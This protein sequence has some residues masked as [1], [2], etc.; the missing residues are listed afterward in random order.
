[1]RVAIITESFSPDVNGVANSVSRVADHLLARGHEPLVI[2]PRPGRRTRQLITPK[3]YPVVRLD[4][5]P[6][7]GY[8]NVRLAWPTRRIGAALRA[9]QPDVVHLASPFILGAWGAR[10]AAGLGLPVVAI[11]QT[12]VPGYARAYGVGLGEAAAWRWIRRIHA[13]AAATLAPSSMTAA[14]L[15]AN[16]VPRVGRWGRGVD[17]EL[18]HPGRRDES[19]RAELAPN[20]ELLVGYVG[21]LA[22][23]KKVELL[24][25]TARVPGVRVVVVGDGPTRDAVR[26]AVPGAVLLGGRRGVELARLYASLDVFVHTGPFETFCQTV[27]EAQASG[28]PV[29]A[30]ATGGPLDLVRHGVDGLLVPPVDAAAIAGA[31]ARLHADPSLRRAYGAA[32]RT[33]V[34]GRTWAALGD[35]LIDHYHA[36]AGTAPAALPEPVPDPA[37]PAAVAAQ[38]L[39]ASSLAVA[40]PVP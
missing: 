5:L 1:M 4:S 26:Q 17:T 15:V 13:D 9:F 21:R 29:V 8:G 3:P 11:Y 33:A 18:F 31:V 20:G 2:A 24:A 28:V 22:K 14:Q 7:P 10:A 37:P 19:L 27:Q 12:D 30:P 38:P 25:Q 35:Q 40:V 34:A 32:A 23:E 6:M 36:A 39:P 16:G